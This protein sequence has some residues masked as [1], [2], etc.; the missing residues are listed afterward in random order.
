M[1]LARRHEGHLPPIRGC[2]R[3]VASAVDDARPANLAHS[4]V[5]PQSEAPKVNNESIREGKPSFVYSPGPERQRKAT[6]PLC[7]K[8][9]KERVSVLRRMNSM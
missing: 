8:G 4:E 7:Y 1:Q 6:Y 9:K 5:K 2:P 3:I